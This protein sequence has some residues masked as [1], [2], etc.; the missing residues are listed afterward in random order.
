VWA[1]QAIGSLAEKGIVK[2]L[3]NGNFAPT[4]SVTRAEFVTMLVRAL[5][6][7]NSGAAASFNDVKQGAWYTDSI[8]AA[9]NAGLVKGSGNGKFEPGREITREEMAIM[10][11]NAL[12]G[13]LP[14]IDTSAVLGEFADKASIAPYAKEAVAQLTQLGIVNGVAGGKFAP[15][16]I[17]NRAQAAVI[18]YRMLE[19]KAS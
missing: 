4:K 5:N 12:A 8:A 16:A 7:S 9:V 14:S 3:E 1:Q 19:N 13:Q 15:K 17:A 10:I 11:V 6:L 18:I 2:G